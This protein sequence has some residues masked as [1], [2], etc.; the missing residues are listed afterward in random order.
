MP[1]P[2]SAAKAA[3]KS[4]EPSS[5][6]SKVLP[7][8]RTALRKARTNSSS[9]K[10]VPRPRPPL[11]RFL[12]TLWGLWSD[13]GPAS[14][15][16]VLTKSMSSWAGL[17]SS[18]A[19]RIIEYSNNAASSLSPVLGKRVTADSCN[20]AYVAQASASASK[21][22]ACRTVATVALRSTAILL[23]V[24]SE[25]APHACSS[26]IQSRHS[27]FVWGGAP[28]NPD[29]R[30]PLRTHFCRSCVSSVPIRPRP[31]P[32]TP[33][34][35][36][37][38]A[39]RWAKDAGYAKFLSRAA[40]RRLERTHHIPGRLVVS[41]NPRWARPLDWRRLGITLGYK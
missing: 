9:W 38:K 40:P 23:Q 21:P 12:C 33:H 10:T 24:P 27:S 26:S 15:A 36:Q 18:S 11:L 32:P 34:A 6:P 14:A 41:R 37:Q 7:A 35:T 17:A 8:S 39:Q 25:S 1:L 2:A 5:V 28:P 29:T 3:S 30:V 16:V 19:A 20:A 22:A 31:R 13:G 4:T